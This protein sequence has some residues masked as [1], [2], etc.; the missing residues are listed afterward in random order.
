MGF[1]ETTCM[2]HYCTC[3]FLLKFVDLSKCLDL[4]RN[5]MMSMPKN[6]K[7]TVKDLQHY[8]TNE[9]ISDV[10]ASPDFMTAN[11]I[12]I[13]CLLKTYGQHLSSFLSILELIKDVPALTAVINHFKKSKFLVCTVL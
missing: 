11:K 2:Q 12:I 6:Y 13:T 1:G 5:L 7:K 3:V 8:L 4:V 10:L 9:E